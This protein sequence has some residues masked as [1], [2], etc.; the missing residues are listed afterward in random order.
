MRNASIKCRSLTRR[1]KN[2]GE[3]TFKSHKHAD[4]NHNNMSNKK[5]KMK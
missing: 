2:W 5:N 3:D 4:K 1:K